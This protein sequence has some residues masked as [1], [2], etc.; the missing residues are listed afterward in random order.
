MCRIHT[1]LTDDTVGNKASEEG[2]SVRPWTNTLALVILAVGMVIQGAAKSGR[3]PLIT[4]YVDNNVKKTKTGKFVGELF[5]YLFIHFYCI[6][7][8]P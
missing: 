4:S 7:I 5:I 8:G 2:H 6:F 3:S 1:A